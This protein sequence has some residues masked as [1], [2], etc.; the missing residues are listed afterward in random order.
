MASAGQAFRTLRRAAVA[1]VLGALVLPV[2]S[3]ALASRPGIQDDLPQLIRARVEA[4]TARRAAVM[5]VGDERLHAATELPRFYRGRG[6]EPAWVSETGPRPV[7]DSLLWAIEGAVLEGLESTHYHLVRIRD[8]YADVQHARRAGGVPEPSRLADLDLLLTDAF[9]VYA[10]HLANGRVDPTTIHPE[11]NV[12][13]RSVDLV[14]ELDMAL[15]TGKVGGVLEA[16]LPTQPGYDR[17]RRVLADYRRIAGQGGWPELPGRTLSQGMRDSAVAVL[18]QRLRMTGDLQA[19]S[20]GA[21]EVVYDREFEEA[22]R[23][24]QRRHS[25]QADGIVRLETSGYLNV[26]VEVR[27]AQIERSMERW[28]WLPRDMGERHILVNI[29]GFEMHVMEG[30]SS[31]FHSRVLVGQRYRKTPVFSD[32]M[33]YLV[34]NPTWTI[35]PGILEED[36]LPLIRRDPGYLARNNIRVLGSNGRVVDPSTIDFNRLTGQTGYRFRMDPGPENPLGRVKFMF[37]NEHHVYLHDTPDH[38]DFDRTWGAVSSGC[39]RV[40]R[41]MDLAELL[42]ADQPGWTRQR[43]ERA[44]A[45]GPTEQHMPLRRPLPI[46][47][48]YWTAWVEPDGTVQFRSDVYDRDDALDEALRRAPPSATVAS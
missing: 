12:S 37:P 14:P 11:W 26:P 22:V 35:P 6:F 32:R 8:I 39:I 33:T 19:P 41:S 24:F 25:I 47:I 5:V 36:K 46:H 7:A 21:R 20:R 27:I 16:L 28:R 45:T 15:A 31:I 1:A 42:L 30:D 44:A 13:R 40:E 38:E 17:L 48:L 2:G 3:V 29:A 34:L 4:G 18:R 43:I 23:R 9:L 10:S